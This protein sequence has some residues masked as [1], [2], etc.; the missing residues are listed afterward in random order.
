MLCAGQNFLFV[1]RLKQ[2]FVQKIVI[3]CFAGTRN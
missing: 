3:D 1:K 2:R